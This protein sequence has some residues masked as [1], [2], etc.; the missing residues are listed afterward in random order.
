M[1]VSQRLKSIDEQSDLLKSQILHSNS[2]YDINATTYYVS[3]SG[4]DSNPGTSPEFPWKTI[5]RVNSQEIIGKANVLF[6]RGNTWRGRIFC[7]SNVTYSAYGNPEDSK[8]LIVG[9]AQ[10]YADP[11]LWEKTEIPYVFRC[12]KKL[13]NVG[14]IALDHCIKQSSFAECSEIVAIKKLN[15]K[16]ENDLEFYSDLTTNDLYMY[17]FFGNPGRRF[18]SIEIGERSHIFTVSDHSNVTIDNLDLRYTGGHA[19]SGSGGTN[20]LTVKNCNISW[21]GGSVHTGLGDG[22]SIQ[23]G[24]AVEIYGPLNGFYV[25]NN[26]VREI[27]DTG[28]TFQFSVLD[29]SISMNNVEFHHNLVERCHWSI[30]WYNTPTPGYERTV[31]NINIHDNIFR[32]G[33]Y[34]WGSRYRR[35]RASLGQSCKL[36]ENTENFVIENNIFDRCTGTLISVHAGGDRFIEFKH[37]TFIQVKNRDFYET[38]NNEILSTDENSLDALIENYHINPELIII[39]FDI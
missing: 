30:E 13:S 16:L 6:L 20:N 9:S 15:N 34:G 8:P 36:S 29:A 26:Y 18:L 32:L 35:G 28:L 23:Y 24:N 10:N 7:K 12:T 37:N 25:Y 2:E 17:S 1:N 5:D 19:I 33:G 3:N 38:I 27:Y 31:K 22:K 21:I 4:D 11:S 39:D 14:I